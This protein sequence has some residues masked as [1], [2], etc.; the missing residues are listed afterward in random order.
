MS[1]LPLQLDDTNFDTLLEG[2]RALIPTLAPQWTDHNLHDPGIMLLELMAWTAEAQI[3]AL[4]RE[5]RDERRAYAALLGVRPSGPTPAAGL[6]WPVSPAWQIVSGDGAIL[7]VQDDPLAPEEGDGPVFRLT[8]DI[9]LTGARLVSVRSESNDGEMQHWTRA[10]EEEGISYEPFS[11]GNGRLILGFTGQLRATESTADRSGVLS[12]GVQLAQ[13]TTASLIGSASGS[14]SC[15]HRPALRATFVQGT[16]NT[17]LEVV[18]D[19]T[20]GLL[21]TG[22]LLLRLDQLPA[23]SAAGFAIELSPP[24]G[25][26]LR[27]PRIDRIEPN[28]LPV[29]QLRT[30]IEDVA[31]P[32]SGMPDQHFTLGIAGLCFGPGRTPLR[33][34][35]SEAGQL[36][37]WQPVA[38]FAASGP[39]EEVFSVDQEREGVSFGNGV[40][41]QIPPAGAQLQVEYDVSEGARGNVPAGR[42]WR[43]HG[44]SG[45][46]GRNREAMSGGANVSGLDDLR[47]QA[48]R[49]SQEER[50]LVTSADLARAALANVDLGIARAVEVTQQLIIS[51]RNVPRGARVLVVVAAQRPSDTDV[52]AEPRV[53]LEEIRRRLSPRLPLGQRLQVLAPAYVDV[54]VRAS[55]V[56]QVRQSPDAIRDRAREQLLG[57][58]DLVGAPDV[59]PWPFGRAVRSLDVKSWLRGLEGVASIVGLTLRASEESSSVD[60]IE[61][62]AFGLPRLRLGADDIS[63]ERRARGGRP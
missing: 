28:V 15:T 27:S 46:F 49:R 19:T 54:F 62:G 3:Y 7:T 33:M 44:I 48:R 26:L 61:I 16:L 5:R 30:V 11:S 14:S 13:S 34:R 22:A 42:S 12:L 20:Q 50:P 35:V 59:T 18:A 29:E 55:L 39:G 57:R 63:V 31:T 6:I 37:E 25:G 8:H 52:A 38:D 23:L 60:R 58:F 9:N 51:G 1:R 36:R 32:G 10:N 2:T 40:N 45:T 4:G 56:A 47:A 17:A 24:P 21:Q 43:A 41:G 53:W